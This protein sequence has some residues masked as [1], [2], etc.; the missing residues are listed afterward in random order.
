MKLLT[1]HRSP[2][3]YFTAEE[4]PGKPL[5]G[6]RLINA[7]ISHNLKW[8]PLPPYEV[9]IARYVRELVG[10][11]EEKNWV[12]RREWGFVRFQATTTRLSKAVG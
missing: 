11:Y 5:L 1:V 6:D 4:N 12:E 9:G 2:D 3:I 7:V 10:K 8:G